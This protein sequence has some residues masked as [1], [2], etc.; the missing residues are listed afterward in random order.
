M[1]GKERIP[2]TTFPQSVSC[3]TFQALHK[4]PS[5][6]LFPRQSIFQVEVDQSG[7]RAAYPETKKM[8]VPCSNTAWLGMCQ[9]QH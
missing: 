1:G 8:S 2:A 3:L 9:S 5:H 4:A 6:A 7:T